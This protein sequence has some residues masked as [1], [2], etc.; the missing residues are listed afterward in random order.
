MGRAG[1]GWGRRLAGP[2]PRRR[3]SPSSQTGHGYAIRGTAEVDQDL[4][5]I[6]AGRI[7]SGAADPAV[8]GKDHGRNFCAD[9]IGN[10]AAAKTVVAADG[11][12]RAAARVRAR[13][14]AVA[15]AIIVNPAVET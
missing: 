2:C 9:G 3:F 15:I 8:G 10:I 11:I 13:A 4:P 12:S 5:H 6:S 1:P 14:V 7:V